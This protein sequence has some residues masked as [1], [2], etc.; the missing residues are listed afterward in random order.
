[1]EYLNVLTR[2]TP[3]Q[4]FWIFAILATVVAGVVNVVR[5]WA[6]PNGLLA[7]QLD[8][9]QKDY[10]ELH[11]EVGELQNRA[12][13]VERDVDSHKTSIAE[14]ETRMRDAEKDIEDLPR[15]TAG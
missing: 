14:L 5:A 15:P 4:F 1:M 7:D 6:R 10:D 13:G 12:D 11:T 9:L 8:D 3:G 2:L